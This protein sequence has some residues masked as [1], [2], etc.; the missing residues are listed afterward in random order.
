MIL[1]NY[2]FDKRNTRVIYIILLN[3]FQSFYTIKY[4]I[5]HRLREIGS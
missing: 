2:F 5:A 3:L 1:I 4:P